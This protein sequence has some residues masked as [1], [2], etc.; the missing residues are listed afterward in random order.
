M[1]CPRPYIGFEPF[2][3]EL[4]D[5]LECARL[6]EE[7]VWACETTLSAFSTRSRFERLTIELQNDSGPLLRR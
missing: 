2:G 3:S 6:F 5:A 1:G 4:C 7:G